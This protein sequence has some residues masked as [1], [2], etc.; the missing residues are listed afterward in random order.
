MYICA[1]PATNSWVGWQLNFNWNICVFIIIFNG[2]LQCLFFQLC[3]MV[4]LSFPRCLYIYTSTYACEHVGQ[5]RLCIA[6]Y[7]V[8]LPTQW[9]YACNA[10]WLVPRP[11]GSHCADAVMIATG[12]CH[13]SRLFPS[14]KSIALPRTAHLYIPYYPHSKFRCRTVDRHKS[15]PTRSLRINKIPNELWC[16]RTHYIRVTKDTLRTCTLLSKP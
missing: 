5:V 10:W 11:S 13:L 7:V 15:L 16:S 1:R 6:L 4:H 3:H 12:T 2:T 14:S 9:S 8:I